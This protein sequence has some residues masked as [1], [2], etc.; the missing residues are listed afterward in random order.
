M[1]K[2]KNP[3]DLSRLIDKYRGISVVSEIENN[4]N[5]E[6]KTEISL[7]RLTISN[8]YNP[9]NYPVETLLP[10]RKSV[11]H[12]GFLVPLIVSKEK[13]GKREILNGVKRYLVAKRKDR[14]EIPT[15]ITTLDEEKKHAYILGSIKKEDKD[16]LVRTNALKVLSLQYGYPQEELSL[17][18]GFSVSQIKNLLRLDNLPKDIKD[19]VH[20]GLLSYGQARVLLNIPSKDQSLLAE[21]AVHS[22][23]SVRD[24]E[25]EKRL[26]NEK[27]RKRKVTLDGTRVTIDFGNEEEARKNYSKILKSFS[28]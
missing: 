16:P 12:Y 28:D 26:L 8:L 7:S 5:R 25:K 18:T 3:S 1:P 19:R 22:R 15:L 27:E 4:L 6:P 21:K 13:D 11:S 2:R 20:K 24:R 10:L 9:E 14:K 23:L 17:M